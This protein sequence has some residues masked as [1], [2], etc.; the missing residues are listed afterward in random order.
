MCGIC[1]I[2]NVDAAEP[3]DLHLVASMRDTL[4]H[5]GPDDFGLYGGRGVGLGHRRLSV[6]DLRPEGRQPMGNEDGSVQI[7]FNGEIY[8]AADHRRAL[9]AKGHSFRSNTDTEVIVHLYEEHGVECLEKLRGMFAFAIW[10]EP[11]RFLF[12]ARDRLGQKPLSYYFDGSKLVFA[13]EIKAILAHP[14]IRAEVDAEAINHYISLGYVPGPLSAFKRIRKLPP[15]HYLT[16]RQG[17]LEVRRYWQVHYFPKSQLTEYEASA[18]V[19]ERLGDAVKLR[20]IS[21]VP[22]GA[23]LSGG[24]DSSAVVAL[25][26]KHSTTP[27]KTFSIGFNTPQFDETRYAREIAQQFGTDHYEFIVEPN[28]I[29]I[30]DDLVWHYDEPFADPASLPTY[31]LCKLTREHVTVA[32]NGDAGDENFAGYQRY[33]NNSMS[34][35]LYGTPAF[36]KPYMESVSAFGARF[37][38]PDGGVERGLKRFREALAN[39]PKL[40]FA[41]RLTQCDAAARRYLYTAEF[42]SQVSAFAAE[43]LILDLYNHAETEE[44][45]EASLSVDLQLYLP[46]ALLAKVDIASMAHGLEARSPMLDHEFVEFAARLPRQFKVSGRTSKAILK[47]A[48]KEMLPRSVLRRRKMGFGVPLDR[49]FRSELRELLQDTLLSRRSA[50]RGYFKPQA[51]EDLIA[52][53]ITEAGNH[54]SQLWNLLVL[55]L[56]HRKYIDA[57]NAPANRSDRWMST[58]HA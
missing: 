48:L 33:L 19:L 51:V 16:L 6:I 29:E 49:W 31:Y 20:M 40:G 57:P 43:D 28:A 14:D 24:V 34:Q 23:F 54:Q 37:F 56:W 3:I 17:A 10:D 53:H 58:A 44:A 46:Y 4:I 32:L 26:A 5:R 11:N 15:A 25:M 42:A 30:L 27:V 45:I 55:E 39:D 8:N 18:Q 9:I 36:L 13:S 2:V 1:G 22:V 47:R 12:L 38:R 50:R 52:A 41:R 35:Q 21:D 7:V